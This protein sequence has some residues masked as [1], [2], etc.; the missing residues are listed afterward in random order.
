[1]FEARERLDA[2]VDGVGK[3]G[4]AMPDTIT[5]MMA[6]M[7][8]AEAPGALTRREKELIAIGVIAY[9]RCEDCV[10]VH[11]RKA[12]EAGATRAEILEA[13]GVA[14][15]FGGGPSLAATAGLLLPAIET[16]EAE[17][18]AEAAAE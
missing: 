11:V 15:V 13:A 10:A 5:T 4:E 6:F 16:Y 14:M 17:L 8:A 7:E 1:M 3:L 2:F 9:H 12:L 18:A